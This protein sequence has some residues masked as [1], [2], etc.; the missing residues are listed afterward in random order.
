MPS[1]H[2]LIIWSLSEHVLDT[3]SRTTRPREAETR[4]AGKR[5]SVDQFVEISGIGLI[6]TMLT[7][8]Q[9]QQTLAGDEDMELAMSLACRWELPIG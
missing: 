2:E 6:S 8:N 9:G 1:G 3:R 4:E 5:Y 7:L